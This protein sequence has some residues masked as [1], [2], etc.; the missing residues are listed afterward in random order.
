[1]FVDNAKILIK[2]G[3]GGAG[4]ASF[5]PGFKSGPDGGNGGKGGDV[6]LVGTNDL[7]ALRPFTKDKVLAAG[8]GVAGGSNRK[9]GSNGKDLD[10]IIPIGTEVK[11]EGTDEVY[12]VLENGERILICKGGIGGR[13]NY[14]LKSP[15]NT[16]PLYAQPGRPGEEKK[17]EFN[18]KLIADFGLIGLP[19]AGK[20]SLLNVLTNA[21]A[22]IANY[23]FTTLEPNLGVYQDK[24]IAD[25]PGLIEGASGG[26]GLGIK[27]LKHI[28]KTKALIHCIGA[29]DEDIEKSYQIV[30]DELKGFNLDLLEK[31][32]IIVLTKSDLLEKA[33]LEKKI[34][35]FK[36]ARKKVLTVS[37]YDDWS[38]A[39]LEKIIKNSLI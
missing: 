28:E 33:D 9:F 5:Y 39:Q 37:I 36:K 3:H 6:Y 31:E 8:S 15:R 29:D 13:G 10:V 19:N 7:L 38:I 14:E 34:K 16:T 22:K 30:R 20:S 2:G 32:E 18:L 11:V 27:F 4:K 12:Q 24:I 21:K 23:P 35:S 26:K 25:I 1:M 17:V